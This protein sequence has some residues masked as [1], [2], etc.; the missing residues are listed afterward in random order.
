[1]LLFILTYKKKLILGI[2]ALMMSP[3]YLSLR[4]LHNLPYI[5]KIFNIGWFSF[6]LLLFFSFFICREYLLNENLEIISSLLLIRT[7]KLFSITQNQILLLSKKIFCNVYNS[8]KFINQK[9]LIKLAIIISP[10]SY[11]IYKATILKIE[12]INLHVKDPKGIKKAIGAIDKTLK[13]NQPSNPPSSTSPL[14]KEKAQI[15][16]M[17]AAEAVKEFKDQNSCREISVYDSH[18]AVP[19]KPYINTEN[20]FKFTNY[21]HLQKENP[22]RTMPDIKQQFENDVNKAAI[23]YE[24]SK[25]MKQSLDNVS[26]NEVLVLLNRYKKFKKKNK[27]ISINPEENELLDYLEKYLSNIISEEFFNILIEGD[28]EKIK[29][30]LKKNNNEVLESERILNSSINGKVKAWFDKWGNNFKEPAFNVNQ[31]KE[32]IASLQEIKDLLEKNPEYFDSESLLLE[33]AR[34]LRIIDYDDVRF[35]NY[36]KSG[37]VILNEAFYN[38]ETKNQENTYGLPNIVEIEKIMKAQN[39]KFG[40]ISDTSFDKENT[41][42][43]SSNDKHV[44]IVIEDPSNSNFFLIL[45][46]LTSAKKEENIELSEYNYDGEKKTQLLHCAKRLTRISKNFFEEKNQ[47][48]NYVEKT[49]TRLL[50]KL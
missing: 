3:Y 46:F 5:K 4:I 14:K 8:L 13:N 40:C 37:D 16:E 7:K 11:F 17:Q 21:G 36:K 31:C 41:F 2:L 26:V 35:P 39:L 49:T 28:I 19:Y 23:A 32:K 43:L 27:E 29:K 48:K 1:M 18:K 45:G 6:F 33:I 9:I 47:I 22:I 12:D 42:L 34:R 44:L 24:F 38:K 30:L 20:K 25:I 50:I 15:P 10:I